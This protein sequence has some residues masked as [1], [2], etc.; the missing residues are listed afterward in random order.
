M[1][2]TE[3]KSNLEVDIDKLM[4][5][6]K[7]VADLLDDIENDSNFPIDSIV[8]DKYRQTVVLSRIKY[9]LLLKE[10]DLCIKLNNTIRLQAVIDSILEDLAHDSDQVS[11]LLDSIK[12]LKTLREIE[13]TFESILEE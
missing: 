10:F 6:Q 4:E 9:D 3:L 7:Q 12:L 13:S 1:L 2:V 8:I 11:D 5:S